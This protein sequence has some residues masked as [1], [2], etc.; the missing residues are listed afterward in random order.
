MVGTEPTQ[1]AL[2]VADLAVELVD[3]T[4]AG[5]DRCLP[6]LGKVES[7]EQPAAAHAEQ[8]GDRAGLAVGEQHGVHALLQARAVADEVQPPARP[9]P[10]RTDERIREPDRRHQ[11][12]AGE[13]G[14]HPG[15]DPVGLAGK[16]RQPFDLLR[17]RDLDLP[18]VKLEPVVHEARAVHR[19]DCCADRSAMTLEPLRQTT[20][21]VGVGRR[22]A[23]VDRP[24][25]RVEQVEVETL[26]TEIQTCVQHR[27]GPPL[28]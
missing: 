15:I 17:I 4:Q 16:R 1:L 18:A 21:T 23:D 12:A 3:Q 25:L 26:A 10:L 5:L 7:G 20:K 9:L 8:I 2:A 28:R 6:R 14:Q 24:S 19:F 22:R 27:S 11:I 13:L